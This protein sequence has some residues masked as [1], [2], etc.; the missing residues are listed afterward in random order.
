MGMSYYG[1]TNSI[2]SNNSFLGNSETGIIFTGVASNNYFYGNN[3]SSSGTTAYESNSGLNNKWNTSTIGNYWKDFQTNPGYPNYYAVPGPGD[4]IDW[5]PNILIF[6]SDN[7]GIPNVQDNC[8][9]IA[10]PDQADSDGDGVGDVCDNCVN[11]SNPDQLD[12]DHDGKGDACET[13]DLP[14]LHFIDFSFNEDVTYYLNLEQYVIDDDV[15]Q[16][17]TWIITGNQHISIDI[18]SNNTARLVPVTNWYGD[19]TVTITVIDGANQSASQDVNITVLSVN[20]P[21]VVEPILPLIGYETDLIHVVVTASDPDNDTV[22][23]TFSPPFDQNGTWQTTYDDSGNYTF[24][25]M[26]TD[27]QAYT[28]AS[29]HVQVINVNRP[30]VLEEIGNKDGQE[31]SPLTFTVSGGDPDNNNSDT[32]D[33]NILTYAAQ[34]LPPGATFSNRQFS[35]T[36]NHYQAG[37][38]P[39]T[40]SVSDGEYVDSEDITLT[41]G[42]MPYTDLVI[43]PS[44]ISFSDDQPYKLSPVTITAYFRNSLEIDPGSVLVRFYNGTPSD[45][46]LIGEEL[47]D[48]NKMST[49][50]VQTVWTPTNEG[51]LNITVWIDPL[52]SIPED[53]ESNNIAMKQL[54]VRTKPDMRIRDQD[55]GF[56]NEYPDSG[57]NITIMAMVRNIES[58]PTGTFTVRFYDGT[59]GTLIAERQMNLPPF[60]T[61][62]VNAT[63]R[64]VS[65]N[66]TIHAYADSTYIVDELREDNNHGQRWINVR[67]IGGSPVFMKPAVS[68]VEKN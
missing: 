49:F 46:T 58:L 17:H 22:T 45:A 65:G 59:W 3:F 32:H 25:V 11:V 52:D 16:N 60:T 19:E 33:N 8:P 36:P 56:S 51:V 37:T 63:W 26:A 21:P 14:Q 18:L 42:N 54:I 64:A 50:F 35:W 34:P 62:V 43:T 61:Q 7:D 12:T 29:F 15:P 41:I 2:I 1:T 10:N 38:Y 53:N 13:N 9:N 68:V 39:L 57:N 48:I 6:D 27:G 20:D 31:A 23:I 4:G 44:D 55:I 24:Y 30:P 40:F 47:L 66:H 67:R 5:H 28:N